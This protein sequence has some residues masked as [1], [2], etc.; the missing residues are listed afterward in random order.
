MTLADPLGVAVA[1]LEEDTV[2]E[3]LDDAVVVADCV[4]VADELRLTL[5]DVEAL[6][7]GLDVD[8][9]VVLVEVLWLMLVVS[10]VDGLLEYVVEAVGVSDAEEEVLIEMVRLAD[11]VPLRECV[12]LCEALRLP[13]AEGVQ[14]PLCV[15]ECV[16]DKLEV[17]EV[18]KL[19][20]VEALLDLD[21]EVVAEVVGVELCVSLPLRDSVVDRVRDALHDIDTD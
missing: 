12:T 20:V 13:D 1:D 2:R 14:L 6:R 21:S 15:G 9:A 8:D 18:L 3:P 16:N 4:L 19:S 5:T 10:V 17:A 11:K 7:L